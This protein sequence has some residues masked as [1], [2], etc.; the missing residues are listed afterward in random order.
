MVDIWLRQ[1]VCQS[2]FRE[3]TEIVQASIRSS[4][5]N[6]TKFVKVLTLEIATHG[7]KFIM[8]SCS[9]LFTIQAFQFRKSL[10]DLSAN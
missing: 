8:A 3:N 7:E 6:Q 5:V 10:F 1:G 2:H 4:A 9:Q